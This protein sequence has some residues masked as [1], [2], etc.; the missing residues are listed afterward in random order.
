MSRFLQSFALPVV[1]VEL[2][3]FQGKLRREPAV[4]WFGLPF[5]PL[6]KRNKRFT[7]QYRYSTR[8]SPDVALP[9]LSSPS[10]GS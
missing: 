6:P 10:V 4:R 3:L 2:Q 1:A 5:T 7:R 9:K 8:V